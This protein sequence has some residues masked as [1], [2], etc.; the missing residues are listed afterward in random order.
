[1]GT[2]KEL[3]RDREKLAALKKEIEETIAAYEELAEKE[4]AALATLA[5]VAR[6]EIPP[7]AQYRAVDAH[8]RAALFQRILELYERCDKLG[9]M[10]WIL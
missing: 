7:D 6:D 3:R 9:L 1:M 2:D 4:A 10:Q 5:F 8:R